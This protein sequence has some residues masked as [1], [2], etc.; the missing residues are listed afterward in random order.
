[1]SGLFASID[2]ARLACGFLTLSQMMEALE[3][4]HVLD[5]FSTLISAGV[6]AGKHNIFYPGVTLKALSGHKIILADDNCVHSGSHFEA[7]TGNILIGSNNQFGEG[8]FTAKANRPGAEIRI[9]SHGRYLNNPALFGRC[10]L[11]NGSQILGSITVDGCTLA[12]GGSYEE[13]DPDL[14]AGLLKG[15]GIARNLTV[16]RGMVIAGN[17][18]FSADDLLPQSHFHPKP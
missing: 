12:D 17:G 15:S 9:G 16:A 2:A 11:G 4:N 13:D 3:G 6:S 5:P 7:A 14:R 1:M 18:T 10:E 8:G